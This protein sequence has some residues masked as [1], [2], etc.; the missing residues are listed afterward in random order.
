MAGGQ[1]RFFFVMM[2]MLQ[3][4]VVATEHFAAS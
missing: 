2:H 1:W 4:T 3:Q